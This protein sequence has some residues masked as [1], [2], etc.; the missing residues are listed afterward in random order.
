MIQK[1]FLFITALLYISCSFNSDS[2]TI[3]R[4]NDGSKPYQFKYKAKDGHY[5]W[6]IELKNN[7]LNDTAKIGVLKLKPRFNGRLFVTDWFSK[8]SVP[9]RYQPYKATSGGVTIICRS[10]Y[11]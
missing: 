9:I 8:D 4:I 5:R 11:F 1:N 10:V 6:S 2:T 3:V 7:T